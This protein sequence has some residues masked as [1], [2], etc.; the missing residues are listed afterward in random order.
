MHP[1]SPGT[2]GRSAWLPLRSQLRAH[3]TRSN[4]RLAAQSQ[5]QDTADFSRAS[6]EAARY[7]QPCADTDQRAVERTQRWAWN[8]GNHYR[9]NPKGLSLMA[10]WVA[11]SVN[12][13]Q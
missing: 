3:Q 2:Q 10:V 13:L 6:K 1:S 12:T 7:S 4:G 11:V 9:R 5:G 8:A